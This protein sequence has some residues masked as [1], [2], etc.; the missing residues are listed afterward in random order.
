[1]A[2]SKAAAQA[3]GRKA[4]GDRGDG[5]PRVT[6]RYL[7]SVNELPWPV[8]F[9]GLGLQAPRF[10]P[11]AGGFMMKC[12][13]YD[14]KASLRFDHRGFFHC[15]RCGCSGDVFGFVLRFLASDGQHHTFRSGGNPFSPQKSVLEPRAYS[16]AIRHF[17]QAHGIGS[18]QRTGAVD[19]IVA[20]QGSGESRNGKGKVTNVSAIHGH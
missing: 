1:M 13:R 3:A 18:N 4:G 2:W 10:S 15:F 5:M 8:V 14:R 9:E 19:G 16:K 12:S 7:A 17:A 11:N 20:C 6:K